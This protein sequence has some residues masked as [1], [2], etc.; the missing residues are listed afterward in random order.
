MAPGRDTD[1][2]ELAWD[3]PGD[4]Q[5]ALGHNLARLLVTPRQDM[6]TDQDDQEHNE[7]KISRNIQQRVVS[8]T[9]PH[10]IHDNI[11]EELFM[12]PNYSQLAPKVHWEF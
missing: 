3:R 8:S 10:V 2:L 11:L 12:L 6:E 4:M 5:G 9:P 7:I 1:W